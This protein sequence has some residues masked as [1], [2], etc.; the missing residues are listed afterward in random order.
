MKEKG[1]KIIGVKQNNWAIEVWFHVCKIEKYMKNSNIF[2]YV[3][4]C[5][6]QR[7]GMMT[8]EIKVEFT[9]V[10]KRSEEEGSFT[11]GPMGSQCTKMLFFLNQIENT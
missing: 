9:S 5:G 7:K 11:K 6:I 1:K 2:I 10:G 4:I 3:L 8:K